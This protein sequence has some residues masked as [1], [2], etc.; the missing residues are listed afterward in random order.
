MP[1]E[2]TQTELASEKVCSV[3]KLLV[4]APDSVIRVQGLDTIPIQR[5]RETLEL[6]GAQTNE[7]FDFAIPSD[8]M[9]VF[10]SRVDALTLLMDNEYDINCY[11]PW[12]LFWLTMLEDGTLLLHDDTISTSAISSRFKEFYNNDID[13]PL[14]QTRWI[15]ANLEAKHIDSDTLHAIQ[16]SLAVGISSVLD[17]IAGIKY[18]MPSCA[19]TERQVV[20]FS[21][22]HRTGIG[23]HPIPD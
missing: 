20:E 8:S 13:R 4:Q 12:R 15:R 6:L 22:Q 1:D 9:L 18:G 7:G 5:W 3:V 23:I 17:Q 11:R 21:Q 2:G 19:L 16:R 14:E 10:G